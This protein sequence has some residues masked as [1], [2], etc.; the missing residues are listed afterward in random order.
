MG[1]FRRKKK[2]T[3]VPFL[4]EATLATNSTDVTG[5][6]YVSRFEEGVFEEEELVKEDLTLYPH[7]FLWEHEGCSSLDEL[8]NALRNLLDVSSIS[9][10]ISKYKNGYFSSRYETTGLFFLAKA[11]YV[12]YYGEDFTIEEERDWNSHLLRVM[13]PEKIGSMV[14]HDNIGLSIAH[15]PVGE[16]DEES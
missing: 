9:C 4:G 5:D 14:Y 15:S 10:Q 11:L 1:W 16:G 13:L 12:D 6:K 3:E 7:L 2:E 8:E